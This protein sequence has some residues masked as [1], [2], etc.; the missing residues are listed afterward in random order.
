M[1]YRSQP[2]PGTGGKQATAMAN[3]AMLIGLDAEQAMKR[4]ILFA[5]SPDTVYRQIMD[6][7]EDV[8][9]FGHFVMVGRSGHMTH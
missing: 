3:A 5:G 1:V 7:Y 2:K 8:G 6:L 4:G 9:G